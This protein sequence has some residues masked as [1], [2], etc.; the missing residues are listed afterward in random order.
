MA[1]GC[2]WRWCI[3]IG[4]AVFSLSLVGQTQQSG[5][6]TETLAEGPNISKQRVIHP[7]VAVVGDKAYVS[8]VDQATDTVW[9]VLVGGEKVAVAT[10]GKRVSGATIAAGMS[11]VCVGWEQLGDKGPEV[12]QRCAHVKLDEKA[13]EWLSDPVRLSTEGVPA[14]Q[15][16]LRDNLQDNWA[17]NHDNAIAPDGTFY[18]VWSENY[19]ILKA[20]RSTDGVK[21]E[22]CGDMT[23]QSGFDV[24]FPTIY[25]DGQGRVYAGAAQTTSTSDVQGWVSFDKCATWKGPTNITNNGGFSEAAEFAVIGDTFY[26]ANDDSTANPD[27]FD[28]NVS[29]CDVTPNG[30]ANCQGTRA[31]YKDA[32]WARLKADGA[33]LHLVGSDQ[34]ATGYVS[35][36]FSSD[37]GAT[38][39]GE[40]IPNSKPNNPAFRDP[41]FG[42]IIARNNIALSS[43]GRVYVV[44]NTIVEGKSKIILSVRSAP[45]ATEAATTCAP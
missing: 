41:D 44:W 37:G 1:C 3:V 25:V 12:W 39:K 15:H 10:P 27:G 19:S 4:L 22:T 31:I 32:A 40:A 21:W 38:W 26:S 34:G 35:Y 6:T 14:G 16:K 9:L 8:Y 13:L 24:R 36:C 7:D 43:D 17:G 28:L 42:I 45:P 23:G 20:A 5:W 2:L 29:V 33:N 18:A 11:S 30:L